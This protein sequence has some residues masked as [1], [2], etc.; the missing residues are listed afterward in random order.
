[1]ILQVYHLIFNHQLV[2][3]FKPG[4]G[5]NLAG[6]GWKQ[7]SGLWIRPLEMVFTLFI[8]F[9]GS[10]LFL[11]V[12]KQPFNQAYLFIVNGAAFLSIFLTATRSW[13]TSFVFGYVFFFFILRKEILK[14]FPKIVLCFILIIIIVSYNTVINTQFYNAWLRV[15]SVEKLVE[16]DTSLGGRAVRYQNYAPKVFE[17]FKKSTIIFGA[18]FSDLFYKYANVH[19]GYHN[20]LLNSGVIGVLIFLGVILK[21]IITSFFY[22]K[23]RT[24]NPMKFAIIPFFCLLIINTG[25]QTI[26]YS[27]L[28]TPF[29]ILQA[30]SL[31]LLVIAYNLNMDN[32]I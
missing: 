8:C 13:V 28:Q 31:A 4:G 2:E 17:G 29:Y 20:H 22:Q 5:R 11:G 7:Y 30:Y 26:G 25:V 10:L 16:G 12:K 27:L 18:G 1:M 21:I 14:Y 3:L 15:S 19:V 32:K 9:S 23:N 24:I 6:F